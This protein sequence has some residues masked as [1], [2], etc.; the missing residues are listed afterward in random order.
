RPICFSETPRDESHSGSVA[1][2]KLVQLVLTHG[3]YKSHARLVGKTVKATGAFFAAQTGHHHTPVLLQVASL[4]PAGAVDANSK[5]R[6]AR[7]AATLDHAA[8]QTVIVIQDYREGLAGVRSANPDV[9][10][11]IGRDPSMSDEAVLLVEY[12]ER[13]DDP[14]GR[15]VR[16]AAEYED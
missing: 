8:E 5:A 16:C 2:V 1:D 13:G 10:L 7:S 11:S 9:R 6:P 14:A 15:D 3:E 12:P 4:E